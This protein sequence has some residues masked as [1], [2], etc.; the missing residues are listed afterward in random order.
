M[1][2]WLEQNRRVIH[3]LPVQHRIDTDYILVNLR[4]DFVAHIVVDGI[5][6]VLG[7]HVLEAFLVEHVII[8][9]FY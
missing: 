6:H 2:T 7:E 1:I 3:K 9:D 5:T 4:L 8:K